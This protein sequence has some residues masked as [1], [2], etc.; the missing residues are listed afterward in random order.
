MISVAYL[1]YA[2]QHD[3]KTKNLPVEN[4]PIYIHG[5][6]NE[7]IAIA[8]SMP[9]DITLASDLPPVDTKEPVKDQKSIFNISYLLY[10]TYG[11]VITLVISFFASIPFGL[12]NP[13]DINQELLTPCIRRFIT[14]RDSLSIRPDIKERST[15]I[16]A[17]EIKENQLTTN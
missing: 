5:C 8:V 3:K 13:K 2:A 12:N 1:L 15:V 14:P 10:T 11:S 9:P 6:S 16:H 17:F 4:K 7:F